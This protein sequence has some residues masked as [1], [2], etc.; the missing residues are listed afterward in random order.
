MPYSWRICC[1]RQSKRRKL[2]TFLTAISVKQQLCSWSVVKIKLISVYWSIIMFVSSPHVTNLLSYV[3]LESQNLIRFAK[4]NVKWWLQFRLKIFKSCR[5]RMIEG[6]PRSGDG[7]SEDV[8]HML[9]Q[10]P[11][12]AASLTKTLVHFQSIIL[13]QNVRFIPFSTNKLFVLNRAIGRDHP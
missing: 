1:C 8:F 13:I 6:F 5:F 2:W 7:V 12:G 11:R 3:P 9:W 10:Q 4:W